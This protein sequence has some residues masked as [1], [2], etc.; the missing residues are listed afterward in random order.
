VLYVGDNGKPHHI[1]AFDVLH[2]GR[3]THGRV[4]ARSAPEHPD[5]LKVD[6]DGRVYASAVDGVRIF[7]PSG[8]Q[9]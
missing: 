5:G 3:L 9:A 7:D 6:A 4:L 8:D 1:L 2:G